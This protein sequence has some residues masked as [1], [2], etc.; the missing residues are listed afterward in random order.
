MSYP[1]LDVPGQ[2]TGCGTG[3][4]EKRSSSQAEPGQAIKSA[5]ASFLSISCATSC[6]RARYDAKCPRIQR[7]SSLSI[8]TLAFHMHQNPTRHPE[9][10]KAVRSATVRP[11]LS[12]RVPPSPATPRRLVAWRSAG[13]PHL[14]KCESRQREREG[15]PSS[16]LRA[17]VS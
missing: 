4:G 10:R 1:T 6:L 17:G 12:R 2:S 15:A 8:K 5:V 9:P 14:N 13:V 7:Q 11:P 3:K 16:P